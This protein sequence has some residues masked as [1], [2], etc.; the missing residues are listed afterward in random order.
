MTRSE[1]RRHIVIHNSPEFRGKSGRVAS[2]LINYTA[3]QLGR[4]ERAVSREITSVVIMDHYDDIVVYV[5]LRGG[6][7][8]GGETVI[9]YYWKSD[10]FAGTVSA[11]SCYKQ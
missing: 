7:F 6:D 11:H 5:S 8:H 1:L 9:A 10:L 3:C 4:K 2:D